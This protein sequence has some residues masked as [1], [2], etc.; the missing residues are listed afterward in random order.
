MNV[1][2]NPHFFRSIISTHTIMQRAE[3]VSREEAVRSLSSSLLNHPSTVMSNY[4]TFNVEEDHKLNQLALDQVF[5]RVD[6]DVLITPAPSLSV[7]VGAGLPPSLPPASDHGGDFSA[8][9]QLETIPGRDSENKSSVR[10]PWGEAE[11][12]A[13]QAA[14]ARHEGRWREIFADTAFRLLCPGRSDKAI[15]D[16]YYKLVADQAVEALPKNVQPSE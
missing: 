13:L 4:L 11:L 1:A 15:R 10:L 3:S 5:E 6:P 14:V 16:R 12:S 8:G 7:C 9:G 2:I